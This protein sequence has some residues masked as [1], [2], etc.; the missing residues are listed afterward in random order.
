[1]R[2]IGVLTRKLVRAGAASV[3]AL[4]VGAGAALSVVPASAA[5]NPE[6]AHA[7]NTRRHL[8]QRRRHLRNYTRRHPKLRHYLRRHPAQRHA[9]LRQR[10]LKRTLRSREHLR[11]Q[12]KG[13]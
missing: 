5:P 10:H 13:R 3:L 12:Y 4:V 2:T 1:M 8:Q 6:A 11:R 9:L 7:V